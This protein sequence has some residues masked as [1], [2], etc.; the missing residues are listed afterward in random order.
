MKNVIRIFSTIAIVYT[1]SPA[2]AN[3]QNPSPG[4]TFTEVSEC[5]EAASLGVFLDYEGSSSRILKFKMDGKEYGA[6]CEAASYRFFYKEREYN[7]SSISSRTDPELTARVPEE[8][9]KKLQEHCNIL[10]R[11]NTAVCDY[12]SFRGNS[13]TFVDMDEIIKLLSNGF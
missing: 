12:K 10:A 1:G 8:A 13:T 11:S 2:F 4:W 3:E 5:L 6:V 7:L 9:A